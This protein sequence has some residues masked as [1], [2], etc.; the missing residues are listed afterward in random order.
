MEGHAYVGERHQ[1]HRGER[2]VSPRCRA[3]AACLGHRLAR[4]VRRRGSRAGED[5][6]EAGE[7]G[8]GCGRVSAHA[9]ATD[10]RKVRRGNQGQVGVGGH[11]CVG[12]CVVTCV[13]CGWGWHW[14]SGHRRD[15]HQR[16][17][18]TASGSH[19][20][21]VCA[22]TASLRRDQTPEYESRGASSQTEL[23]HFIWRP[24]A[25]VI[26]LRRD[27]YAASTRA[28]VPRFSR[29]CGVAT[30]HHAHA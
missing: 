18:Q 17:Y 12:V 5:G 25:I 3:H 16:L 13:T 21:V 20:C 26:E 7:V 11:V 30:C 19:V 14:R 9:S 29:E 1:A 15:T 27:S 22:S 28:P 4:M 2:P 10:R 6:E 23:G 8:R 24:M